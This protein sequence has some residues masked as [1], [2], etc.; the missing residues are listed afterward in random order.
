MGG[1]RRDRAE[2]RATIFFWTTPV[3]NTR[4]KTLDK[5]SFFSLGQGSFICEYSLV[6]VSKLNLIRLNKKKFNFCIYINDDFISV[7]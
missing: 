7:R 2:W 3:G 6:E 4:T 1:C 5:L